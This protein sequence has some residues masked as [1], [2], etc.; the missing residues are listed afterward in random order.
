MSDSFVRVQLN[1][2]AGL[3]D[4]P[5][6]P[7]QV[8]WHEIR[9][10]TVALPALRDVLPGEVL[11]KDTRPALS[12]EPFVVPRDGDDVD[13]VVLVKVLLGG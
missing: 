12:L 6:K 1:D 3:D 8:R 11:L 13:S 5:L 9:H 2:S 7:R 10:L 4:Q